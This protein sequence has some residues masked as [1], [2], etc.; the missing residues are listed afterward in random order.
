MKLI[1]KLSLLSIFLL[2]NS[3]NTYTNY[4][5]PDN[6][7]L[8]GLF[9]DSVNLS[10]TLSIG[11][12]SWR[13]IFTDSDLTNLIEEGLKNNTDLKKALLQTEEAEATLTQSRAAF[14]PSL[15]LTSEG[16]LSSYDGAKTSKT[17]TLGTSASWEIDA[18]GALRNNQKEKAASLQQSQAATLAVKSKLIATIADGYY[19]LLMLDKQLQITDST[20]RTWEEEINTRKALK[21]AGKAN[22]AEICQAQ[23]N[24]LN[25]QHS[26]LKLKQQINQQE[27]SLSTLIGLIPQSIKRSS[28]DNQHFPASLSVGVPLSLLSR[29][30]DICQKEYALKESFYSV[31]KARS[32]FYPSITL[33]GTAGWTNNRG[34]AIVNPGKL[35]STALG[36]LIQ[37][38]FSKGQN[39]ANLKIAKAKQ[40]EALLNYCQ[41]I[42]DAGSEVNTALKQWQTA[43]N[44]EQTNTK[45]IERLATALQN[46]K[47]LM[48]SGTTNYLDVLNA[49]QSLLNTK[50]SAITD[51]YDEIQGIINL[52]HALGGGFY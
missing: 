27:N 20:R 24:C 17:Y 41:A 1:Y 44:K 13:Q 49:E 6:L 51:K 32:A 2:L 50:L 28:I 37:P 15:S 22:E 7:P 29:R 47:L 23:A 16:K 31:N 52:Y 46:T 11:T 8:K 45:Q 39:E 42:L 18:F 36:S 10:D 14:L 30:P 4:K 3:C 19:S 43:L 35:L 5:R 9:R 21:E 48:E 34:M 26:I 25:A 33:S 40:Q 38:V 12:L